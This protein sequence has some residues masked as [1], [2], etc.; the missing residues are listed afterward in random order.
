MLETII[1]VV[2]FAAGYFAR[3]AVDKYRAEKRAK[4]LGGGG[5]PPTTPK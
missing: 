5:P 4:A 2:A 1:A 3:P